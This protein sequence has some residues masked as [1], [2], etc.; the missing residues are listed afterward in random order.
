MICYTRKFM[1]RL[2]WNSNR[3]PTLPSTHNIHLS[4]FKYITFILPLV[5]GTLAVYSTW[6]K[7]YWHF[8]PSPPL[9]LSKADF[10][11]CVHIFLSR[12]SLSKQMTACFDV[13]HC[14]PLL[15]HH[16]G[17]LTSFPKVISSS[18]KVTPSKYLDCIVLH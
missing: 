15:S 9:L 5:P 1:P 7:N 3:H 14:S 13:V 17:L 16:S 4:G 12:C 8:S 2:F 18:Q 11:C 6:K 10:I